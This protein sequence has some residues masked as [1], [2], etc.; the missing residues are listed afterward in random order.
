M[1]E[2]QAR[3]KRVFGLRLSSR[4]ASSVAKDKEDMPS[5]TPIQPST[6][7]TEKTQKIANET[8]QSGYQGSFASCLQLHNH[9]QPNFSADTDV[10]CTPIR[11]L[12][13]AA[14]HHPPLNQSQDHMNKRCVVKM[15]HF[16]FR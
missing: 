11:Q 9:N 1:P 13:E 16:I 15:N 2:V 12:H 4:M 6:A 8:P 3:L 5:P 10:I 7:L 14:H